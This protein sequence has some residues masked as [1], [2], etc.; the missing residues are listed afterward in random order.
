MKI[1]EA[2]RIYSSRL[3]ELWDQKRAYLKQQRNK[4]ENNSSMSGSENGVIIEWTDEKEQQYE[5]TKAFMNQLMYIKN[6]LH[7]AEVSKQ[8][9]NVMTEMAKDAAKCLEIA[10]RISSG[11]KVPPEDEKKLMEY[12]FEIYLAA[13]NAAAMNNHKSGKN[14]K[15]LWEEEESNS[16]S[17]DVDEAIDEMDLTMET[18]GEVSGDVTE[19]E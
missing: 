15:S 1:G 6:G 7:N 11:G 12:S 19:S 9:G 10:R 13:K 4:S 14:Y 8:Q 18:P 5:E 17:Q 2:Q 16:E 3:N